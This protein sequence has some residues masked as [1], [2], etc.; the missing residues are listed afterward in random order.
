M[1]FFVL[2]SLPSGVADFG[3]GWDTSEKP[4][5]NSTVADVHFLCSVP[6]KPTYSRLGLSA[7]S[8]FI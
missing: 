7:L 6:G 2:Y 8:I 3:W 4:T 1:L 5:G